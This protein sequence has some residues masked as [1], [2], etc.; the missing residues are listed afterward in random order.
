MMQHNGAGEPASSSPSLHEADWCGDERRRE[1]DGRRSLT[2]SRFLLIIR[3]PSLAACSRSSALRRTAEIINARRLVLYKAVVGRRAQ[4]RWHP[5]VCAAM[6]VPPPSGGY[7]KYS[8]P[9]SQRRGAQR[10][11]PGRE[12]AERR[13]ASRQCELRVEQPVCVARLGHCKNR[14]RH[15]RKAA[16]AGAPCVCMLTRRPSRSSNVT[17]AFLHSSWF[18]CSLRDA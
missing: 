10:Q 8:T 11:G 16:I 13:T 3:L 9:S 14:L 12:N 6:L 15:A 4:A 18:K 17:S 5:S 2:L 1:V 7:L